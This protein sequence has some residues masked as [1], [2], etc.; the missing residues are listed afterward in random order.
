MDVGMTREKITSRCNTENCISPPT[1]DNN[2]CILHCKKNTTEH[3]VTGDFFNA[4]ALHIAQQVHKDNPNVSPI[5]SIKN[6]LISAGSRSYSN[7]IKNL[8]KDSSIV[9]KNIAFPFSD[10]SSTYNHEKLFISLGDIHFE[11]C[12]FNFYEQR[13][14][15]E[16]YFFYKSCQFL[17]EYKIPNLK[18]YQTTLFEDCIFHQKVYSG[19]KIIDSALFNNCTFKK[20]LELKNLDFPN[21]VFIN[22]GH[23]DIKNNLKSLDL[24]NC[25]FKAPFILSDYVIDIVNFT[26]TSFESKFEFKNNII[27]TCNVYNSNFLALTDFYETTFEKL[28]VEKSIFENFVGFEHCIFG[29]DRK[30]S[31]NITSFK[32]ATFLDFVNFRNT[33]FK[34][35]LDIEN[36]N[37]KESPNFLNSQISLEESNRETF[38]IIKNSFDK[39]GNQIEAN[40]FFAYEMKKYRHDLSKKNKHKPKR[41]LLV[42][43]ELISDFGQSYIKPIVCLLLSLITFT[44]ITEYSYLSF[45]REYPLVVTLEYRLN[46]LAKNLLPL[47]NILKPNM[48]FVSLIFYI[49]FASLIWQIIVA[50]KR[51]TKR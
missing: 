49:V 13:E 15:K 45:M 27:K 3:D 23:T 33:D 22:E 41:F 16:K 12:T 48:E 51:L 9:L 47:S 7:E 2:K 46:T 36:I 8:V 17:S 19:S 37:L 1:P 20:S 50:V 40:R 18:T 14:Y 21:Q 34:N 10:S 32:Y 28:K 35:G 38:R 24:N 39:I 26:D 4:L 30:S 5:E 31:Q 29:I 11:K 6:Y 44:V 43:N 42:L 25:T